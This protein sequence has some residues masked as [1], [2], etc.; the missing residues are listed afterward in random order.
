MSYFNNK[1]VVVTGGAGFLATHFITE[2]SKL[3][4]NITTY[5]YNSP[6]QVS[7]EIQKDIKI[8]ENM[9]LNNLDDA[10]KLT[11]GADLVIHCAGHVLHPG[12][13]ELIYKVH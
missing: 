5:T 9:H 7:E 3:G 10:I 6:L 1:E 12:S 4:A 13:D 8:I 11:S 2:L